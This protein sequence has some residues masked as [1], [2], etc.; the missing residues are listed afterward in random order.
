MY[1]DYTP[2]AF[3]RSSPTPMAPHGHTMK[4]IARRA[5]IEHMAVE[6]LRLSSSLRLPVPVEEIYAHPPL[7]LWIVDPDRTPPLAPPSD[8]TFAGR[9]SIA[10]AIA[11]LV[12]ESAWTTRVR[13]MST[14]PFTPDD[15]ATFAD[16][17]LVPT[18]LLSALNDR[19]RAPQIVSALFQ[20]PLSTAVKRLT[21]LGYLTADPKIV[22]PDLSP[23]H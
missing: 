7:Q 18:A 13:L 1:N 21:E 16:T 9:Q 10:Q 20:V 8:E 17:L 2:S 15:I 6:L 23:E 5:R 14:K 22:Q 12:G 4:I 11:R 19:Q 3:A